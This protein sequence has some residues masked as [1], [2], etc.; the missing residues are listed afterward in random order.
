M[1]I[2]G[3]IGYN[4]FETAN[5]ICAAIRLFEEGVREIEDIIN[6]VHLMHFQ[7]VKDAL[8]AHKLF[9]YLLD[10]EDAQEVFIEMFM[11]NFLKCENALA[12][13]DATVNKTKIGEA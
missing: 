5:N 9:D 8:F 11:E 1:N 3:L 4:V 12:A 7:G 10:H 6:G 2:K 13:F